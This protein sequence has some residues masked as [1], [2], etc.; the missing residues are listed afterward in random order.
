MG[1]FFSIL[2][3][4]LF[5][6]MCSELSGVYQCFLISFLSDLHLREHLPTASFRNLPLEIMDIYWPRT[7]DVL[8]LQLCIKRGRH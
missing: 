5:L 7:S 1:H 8:R 6:V 3:E 2:S 4:R